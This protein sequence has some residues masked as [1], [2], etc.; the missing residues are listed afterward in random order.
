MS[1]WVDIIIYIVLLGLIAVPS[2][3]SNKISK[4]TQTFPSV[5]LSTWKI[6]DYTDY[7]VNEYENGKKIDKYILSRKLSNE[8]DEK[9][10]KVKI[11]ELE[12]K[13]DGKI[14]VSYK[15]ILPQNI[16][17]LIQKNPFYITN[18]TPN[19]SYALKLKTKPAGLPWAEIDFLN[20]GKD[21]NIGGFKVISSLPINIEGTSKKGVNEKE[22]AEMNT[23]R[24]MNF[25][26][27]P[28]GI[29]Y[30]ALEDKEANK[31]RLTLDKFQETIKK[32]EPIKKKVRDKDCICNCYQG[33]LIMPTADN[34]TQITEY[35][36]SQTSKV[37]LTGV[38]DLEVNVEK[39]K[40]KSRI[41]MIL[42]DYGSK[43]SG[44]IDK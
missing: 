8:I 6:G 40:K 7:E 17:E 42:V 25:K 21:V 41:V 11:V 43:T 32:C 9:G 18:Y 5:S 16:E 31:Y 19:F 37:P 39:E 1:K 22:E 23:K 24:V 27:S 34:N 35:K 28:A 29:L 30:E 33:K 26:E 38:V 36:V 20:L 10:Q 15:I 13:R 2:C 12:I 14:A 4:E 44:A 3:S